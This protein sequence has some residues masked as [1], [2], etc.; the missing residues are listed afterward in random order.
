MPEGQVLHPNAAVGVVDSGIG[1]LSVLRALRKYLPQQAWVYFA[2]QAHLPYGRRPADQLQAFARRI[3][4]FLVEREGIK[5]LVV[6]CN[7][8]SAVALEDLRRAWPHLPIVGIEPAIKPAVQLSQQ[9]RV[10]VLATQ[11]TLSSPRYRRLKERF[12]KQVAFWEDPCPGLVEDIEEHGPDAP[13]VHSLLQRALEPMQ[14]AGVDVVVL[15][16]THYPLV[17]HRIRQLLGP[18]VTL[19]DPAQAVARRLLQVLQQAQLEPNGAFPDPVVRYYTTGPAERLER[20]IT[21]LAPELLG[22][23][24]SLRDFWEGV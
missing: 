8:L 14:R 18:Q 9:G 2:D 23:I 10:G 15:G 21:L 7:T 19:V 3:T 17:A 13:T 6:A 11:V 12:G 5:A 20:Q 24:H 22:P 1:G 4:R 16:C